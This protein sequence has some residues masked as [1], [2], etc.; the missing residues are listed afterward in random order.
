MS[1][2]QP[3]HKKTILMKTKYLILFSFLIFGFTSCSSDDDKVSDEVTI[4]GHWNTAQFTMEGTFVDDNVHATFNGV[5]NNLTGNDITF[6]SDN[7]I[8]G[9]SAPFNMDINYV[10][11]GMPVTINQEMS[12]MM[13]HEGTWSRDGE[14]LYLQESGSDSAQEFLIEVHN[15]STLKLSANQDSLDLGADFPAGAQFS[16]TI[17]YVR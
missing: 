10:I 14:Y 2:F 15:S 12:S 4:L 8:T 3:H 9:N 13:V 6:H 17:T 16:V 7:T 1:S 5:A 11:D